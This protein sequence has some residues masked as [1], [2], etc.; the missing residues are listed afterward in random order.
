MNEDE[1]LTQMTPQDYR[2]TSKKIGAPQVVHGV[3]K[4][5]QPEGAMIEVWPMLFGEDT[6]D[7][8]FVYFYAVDL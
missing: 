3:T 2:L 7:E 4:E 8:I 5:R 1:I 6:P